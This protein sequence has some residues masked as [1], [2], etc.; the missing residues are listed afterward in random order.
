MAA[1]LAMAA[2]GGTAPRSCPSDLPAACPSTVPSFVHDVS[3]VFQ[4]ACVQ[5]HRAGGSAAERPLTTYAQV[6]SQRSAVLN[7]LYG[8][9]M[10][11]T[12]GTSLTPAQRLAVLQWLVCHAPEN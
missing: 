5:C 3:P 11:P 9:R 7:Q 4:S 8:C 1:L 2:C 12:D 10:P 6:A